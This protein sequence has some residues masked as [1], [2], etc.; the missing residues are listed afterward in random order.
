MI[1]YSQT[2]IYRDTYQLLLRLHRAMP[3]IPREQRYTIGRNLHASLIE[4]E[5]LVFKACSV[6]GIEKKNY[7]NAMRQ[8]LIEVEILLRL[9]CD[10]RGISERLYVDIC[11]LV[12][13]LSKQMSLWEQKTGDAS[14]EGKN[15]KSQ[16]VRG[17]GF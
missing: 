12:C 10:L 2:Q 15:N 4:I 3:H 16:I 5:K 14:S 13:S 9:L 11:Q 8:Q 7:I 1:V 6:Y 17:Q